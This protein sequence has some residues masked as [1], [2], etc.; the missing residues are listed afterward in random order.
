MSRRRRGFTLIELLVVI[1]IIGLLIALLLPALGMV[2]ESS[3]RAKCQ[4]NLKQIGVA[5]KSYHSTHNTYPPGVIFAIPPWQ[6][7]S[8]LASGGD[9]GF[10]QNAL[11]SLLTQIEAG[12]QADLYNF[13][14]N[15]WDQDETVAATVLEI[16]L[17]PS[18]DQ[19]TI[20][21][22]MAANLGNNPRMAA[23]APSH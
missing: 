13:E 2:M 16:F 12:A 15:W 1:A 4:S 21:E 14:L 18:S 7:A 11:S 10:R 9:I 17:C 19:T 20:L 3:R 23:F 22:P 5:L 6:N 8:D